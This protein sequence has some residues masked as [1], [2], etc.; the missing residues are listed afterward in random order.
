L[1]WVRDK[2]SGEY[3]KG[4]NI[5]TAYMDVS[6]FKS[7]DGVEKGSKED[8]AKEARQFATIR[9]ALR[10]GSRNH[11]HCLK[12]AVIWANESEC[13]GAKKGFE[14]AITNGSAL[15]GENG[16]GKCLRVSI[17]FQ[18]LYCPLLV[19]REGGDEVMEGWRSMW[20]DGRGIIW[21]AEVENHGVDTSRGPSNRYP[22]G[23][24]R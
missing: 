9:V 8:D 10:Q 6:F 11:I 13:W 7:I 17:K 19:S 15:S 23:V 16:I 22:Y 4:R 20:G 21:L 5:V 12:G 3:L 1:G 14:G 24:F 2:V 18:V